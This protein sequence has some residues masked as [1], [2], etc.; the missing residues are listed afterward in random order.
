MV[1]YS[2][3]MPNEKDGR[4]MAPGDSFAP[5]YG[6]TAIRDQLSVRSSRFTN[7]I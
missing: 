4:M 5:F 7:A 2:S 1:W 6:K 3:S